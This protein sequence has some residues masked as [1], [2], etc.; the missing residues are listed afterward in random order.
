MNKKL[1]WRAHSGCAVLPPSLN[2]EKYSRIFVR[3]D[4]QSSANSGVKNTLTRTVTSEVWTATIQ[5]ALDRQGAIAVP[6]CAQ[7]YYLDPPLVSKVI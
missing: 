4:G 3:H 1:S 2:P 6:A 7:P 5:T